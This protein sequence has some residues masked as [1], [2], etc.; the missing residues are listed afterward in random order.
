MGLILKLTSG[1][2]RNLTKPEIHIENLPLDIGERND[3]MLAQ[4]LTQSLNAYPLQNIEIRHIQNLKQQ[5]IPVDP[6]ALDLRVLLLGR[7]P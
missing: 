3:R 7:K 1:V 2:S 5:F 4:S 6:E